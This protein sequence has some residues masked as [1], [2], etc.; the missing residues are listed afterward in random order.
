MAGK[1]PPGPGRGHRI[2]Q[3]NG[4][5]SGGPANG[6]GW[7]GPASGSPAGGT[8]NLTMRNYKSVGERVAQRQSREERVAEANEKLTHL[9]RGAELETTQLAAAVALLNRLEGLPVARNLNMQV[10]ALDN[11]DIGQKRAILG[12]LDRPGDPGPGPEA[13]PSGPAS[14]R[15]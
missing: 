1:R 6:P 5:E 15:H 13:I 14:T 9:M 12:A 10:N 11:L 8:E 4:P 2:K 3:G 7:G